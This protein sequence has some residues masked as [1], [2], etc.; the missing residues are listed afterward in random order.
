LPFVDTSKQQD[1]TYYGCYIAGG[2]GK[3][4]VK[5]QPGLNRFDLTDEASGP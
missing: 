2:Y 3:Q 5:K 1:N 4:R